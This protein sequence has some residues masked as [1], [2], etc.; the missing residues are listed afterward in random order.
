MEDLGLRLIQ[1]QMV[2]H[3]FAMFQEEERWPQMSLAIIWRG[4]MLDI[5]GSVEYTGGC[6]LVVFFGLPYPI[7]VNPVT[8]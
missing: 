1:K 8:N 7:L 3:L 6:V 4:T 2:H 5:P